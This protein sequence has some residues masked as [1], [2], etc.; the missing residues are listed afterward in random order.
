MIFKIASPFFGEKRVFLHKLQLVY[1]K[2]LLTLNWSKKSPIFWR[3]FVKLAKSPLTSDWVTFPLLIDGLHTY[4]GKIVLKLQKETTF[5]LYFIFHIK[6][7]C[8]KIGNKLFG[9]HFGW[10][11]HRIILSTWSQSH[12]H[13][14]QR[15]RCK[16]LQRN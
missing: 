11:F 16:N 13:E 9:L 7:L 3:K 15:Q 14:L 6:K 4:F 1:V 12:D 5:L 10:L 8:I 2:M